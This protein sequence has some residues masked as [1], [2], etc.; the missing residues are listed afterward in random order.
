MEITATGKKAYMRND[1][2]FNEAD[3]NLVKFDRNNR[4]W[5]A[6]NKGVVMRDGQ[7]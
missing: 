3:A 6:T 4:L 2:P 1:Y 5:I 7:T